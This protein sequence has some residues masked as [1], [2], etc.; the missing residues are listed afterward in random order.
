MNDEIVEFISNVDSTSFD[1]FK[2][3][4]NIE[5][6][7]N[8]DS[9]IFDYNCN[10]LSQI[11][12]YLPFITYVVN[13]DYTNNNN[14]IVLKSYENRVIK[15]LIYRLYDYLLTEKNSVNNICNNS[16]KSI[17]ASI[18]STIDNEEIEI[19]LSIKSKSSIDDKKEQ[20]I[21][22]IIDRIDRLLSITTNLLDSEFIKNLDDVSL[23]QENIEKTDLFDQ[24]INY[25]K[26]YE[27]YILLEQYILNSNDEKDN[28]SIEDRILVTSYLDY[29]LFK[30]GFKKYDNPNIYREYLEKIIEKIVAESS[31]DEKSFKKMLT[32]KFEGEYLKKKNREK[33]IQ[34]VFLK[35]QD[36]YNKQ[37]KDALRAL[38]D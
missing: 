22:S 12:E 4:S 1:T 2:N 8:I 6:D 31:M 33:S 38:K 19:N 15:T 17:N 10:W 30:E 9:N 23:L 36:N 13:L 34:T 11:E 32:K 26:A 21:N 37:V 27:L 16:N 24:D 35:T 25:K 5:C 3:N 28:N 18:K 7:Y 29:Q 20:L 14:S